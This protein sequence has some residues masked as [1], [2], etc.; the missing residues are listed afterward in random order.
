[1]TFTP[2]ALCELF[3]INLNW[4]E[5]KMNKL[6]FEMKDIEN[7]ATVKHQVIYDAAEMDLEVDAEGFARDSTAEDVT[8]ND[9]R[10]ASVN[11]ASRRKSNS[12]VLALR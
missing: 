5:P 10:V 2:N 3:M 6:Q 12:A 8:F 4:G 9:G 1:M 7:G 11:T